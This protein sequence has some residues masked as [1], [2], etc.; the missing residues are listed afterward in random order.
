MASWSWKNTGASTDPLR[1]ES[2][3]ITPPPRAG[4]TLKARITATVQEE[5][6]DGAYVDVVVKLGYIKVFQKQYDL[7]EHLRGH[8]EDWELSADAVTGDERL[9]PGKTDRTFV[10]HL[11]KDM[12][13]KF[14]VFVGVYSTENDDLA[15][16]HFTFDLLG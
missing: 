5:V 6:A 7:S 3:D 8:G 4:D 16:L 2:I 10:M 11:P 15:G 1:I 12:H 9:K 14:T 13:A